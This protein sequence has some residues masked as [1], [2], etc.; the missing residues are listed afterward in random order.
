M[1]DPIGGLALASGSISL[2][3]S[4]VKMYQETDPKKAKSQ[5][6]PA[7]AEVLKA[8]PALA[9]RTSGELIAE[10]QELRTACIRAKV[11]LTKSVE[12]NRETAWFWQRGRFRVLDRFELG[13]A[14]IT[15]ELKLFFDDVVAVANCSQAE[16]LVARGF[17]ESRAQKD[18]LDKNLQEAKTLGAILDI[19]ER[20]ATSLRQKLGPM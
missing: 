7:M 3:T 16:E 19:F 4:L 15:G 5:A 12:D 2:L 20:E 6:P 13:V 11:D 18:S 17:A 14:K 1:P 8:L 9:F 10:V